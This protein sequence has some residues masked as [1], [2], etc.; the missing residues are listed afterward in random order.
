MGKV[1]PLA[2]RNEMHQISLNLFGT[3]AIRDPET[4]TDAA[5]MGVDHDTAGNSKRGPQQHIGRFAT[6]SGELHQ[7]F[8]RSGEFTLVLLD[9]GLC[10]SNQVFRFIAEK[11]SRLN[12]LLQL[13]GDR[14]GELLRGGI[15]GKQLRCHLVHPFIR[16]LCGQNRGGEKLKRGLMI[17]GT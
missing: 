10:H 8:Q 4:L 15:P 3:L 17:Q 11:T 14:F 13:L 1:D 12:H 5:D 6:D 2:L 9:H 7:F 16:T